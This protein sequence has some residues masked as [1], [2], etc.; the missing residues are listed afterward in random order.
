MTSNCTRAI[1][2]GFLGDEDDTDFD[3]REPLNASDPIFVRLELS[4]AFDSIFERGQLL[5]AFDVSIK[6]CTT[7]G[8]VNSPTKLLFKEALFNLG[9]IGEA[10]DPAGD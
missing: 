7:G 4:G 2:S 3:G 9:G 5:E 8:V 6:D 10:F 1:L